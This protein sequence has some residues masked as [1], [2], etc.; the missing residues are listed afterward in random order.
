M[1]DNTRICNSEHKEKASSQELKTS[2]IEH[3]ERFNGMRGIDYDTLFPPNLNLIPPENFIKAWVD[4]YKTMQTNIIPEDSPSFTD[5][6]ET[7]KKAAKEYN[8]LK[9]E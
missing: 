4:D 8:A 3:R 5:F 7:V 1:Y 9:F 6:L 2:I